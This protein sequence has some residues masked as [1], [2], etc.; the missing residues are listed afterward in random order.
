[1]LQQKEFFCADET[2]PMTMLKTDRK[3]LLYCLNTS[4]VTQ[5][6][7]SRELLFRFLQLKL[8]KNL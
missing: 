3:A 5:V 4:E 2:P 1:M 7:P 8:P 6:E